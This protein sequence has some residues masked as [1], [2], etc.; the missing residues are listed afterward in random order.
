MLQK[1]RSTGN[2]LLHFCAIYD[3]E[4][5]GNAK[6]FKIWSNDK[7]CEAYAANIIIVTV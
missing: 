2:D 7:A 6:T 1:N 3:R 4:S 5:V